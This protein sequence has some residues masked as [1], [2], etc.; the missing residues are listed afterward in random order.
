MRPFRFA[1]A[2]ACLALPASA[3]AGLYYS[4]E[5]TAE[6]PAQWRGFLLDQRILRGI[7]VKPAPGAPASPARL[8][9]QE[10]AAKL[11]KLSQTRKLTA[12]EMADLGALYVR[13]GEPG[14][15]I[16][17]LRPAQRAHPRHF[18]I[19]ANLGTAFQLQGDLPQA[20]LCLEQAVRLAPG[21]YQKAEEYHLK[22]VRL[23]LRERGEV[24]NVD[25]LFGVRYVDD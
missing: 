23:R 24:R 14:R 12:D 3:R 6:L 1:L 15:A 13:L 19:A 2:A 10:A 18:L 20:V 21:K 7:A 25:D 11:E 16:A 4:G 5:P 22:L 17:L 8:R 9:Y